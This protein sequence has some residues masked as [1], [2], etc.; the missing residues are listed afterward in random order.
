MRANALTALWGMK[1]RAYPGFV[2][3]LSSM[4]LIIVVIPLRTSISVLV[5][6]LSDVENKTSVSAR[7]PVFTAPVLFFCCSFLVLFCLLFICI[8]VFGRPY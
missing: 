2:A 7:R 6:M 4:P 1:L 3:M 8:N 5:R